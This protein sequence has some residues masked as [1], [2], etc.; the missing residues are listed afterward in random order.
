VNLS[1]SATEQSVPSS[2]NIS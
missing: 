1:R 2:R